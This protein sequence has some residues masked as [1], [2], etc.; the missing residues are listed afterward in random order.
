MAG[1][2]LKRIKQNDF[3]PR[4]PHKII[5]KDLSQLRSKSS[6]EHNVFIKLDANPKVKAW[7]Y[8]VVQIPYIKATDGRQ[9]TYYVDI[10]SI[11]EIEGDDGIKRDYKLLFEIKPRKFI[12]YPPKPKRNTTAAK[13]FYRQQCEE[14]SIN[15]SKFNAAYEFCQENG[16]FFKIICYEKS[17]K[18]TGKQNEFT[19]ID[20]IPQPIQF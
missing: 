7:G 6:W 12:M 1:Y 3:S 11:E 5:N 16:M 2:D 18:T 20:W 14:V 17:D 8:E 13:N 15:I 4:N 10:F 19:V 9:H